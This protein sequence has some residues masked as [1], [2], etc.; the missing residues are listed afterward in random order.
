MI[1]HSSEIADEIAG[2]NIGKG[3]PESLPIA[4]SGSG[5]K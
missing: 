2:I 1:T 3:S 5:N 4:V